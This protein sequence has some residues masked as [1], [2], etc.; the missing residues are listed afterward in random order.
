[1]TSTLTGGGGGRSG[2]SEA[3]GGGGEAGSRRRHPTACWVP[4]PDEIRRR[5]ALRMAA[6]KRP[7]PEDDRHV[8]QVP[9][10]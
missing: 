3:G 4:D 9:E 5:L 10:P 6:R 1:M 7:A 2:G 8:P